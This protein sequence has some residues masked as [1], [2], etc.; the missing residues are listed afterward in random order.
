MNIAAGAASE[1]CRGLMRSAEV[2]FARVADVRPE[3]RCRSPEG[4]RRSALGAR[5]APSHSRHQVE[6]N[7]AKKKKSG[8]RWP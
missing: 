1:L 6:A 7:S 3:C 8:A 2:D 5:A 4:H